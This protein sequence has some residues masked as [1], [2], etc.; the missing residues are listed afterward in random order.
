MRDPLQQRSLVELLDASF[1]VLR[2]CWGTALRLYAVPVALADLATAFLSRASEHLQTSWASAVLVA[3]SL[4]LFV[5]VSAVAG[6]ALTRHLADVL[7]PRIVDT[8]RGRGALATAPRI[9]GTAYLAFAACI[10]GLA[11]LI[12]P[13]IWLALALFLVTPIMV[14]ER[15]FGV[16]ALRR[17]RALMRGHKRR[18]LLPLLFWIACGTGLDFGSEAIAGGHVLL[19]ELSSVAARVL[20]DVYFLAFALL[21]YL[22]SRIRGEAFDLEILARRVALEDRPPTPADR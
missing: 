9:L 12:A 11:L 22:D 1:Y 16:A 14:N 13:G 4:L 5:G 15:E 10:A 17:S 8:S 7:V 19:H 3:G 18:A 21:L 2:S 20:L 6:F